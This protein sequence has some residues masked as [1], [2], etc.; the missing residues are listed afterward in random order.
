MPIKTNNELI[1]S[2]KRNSLNESFTTLN[3]KVLN[4]NAPPTITF[5][6]KTPSSNNSSNNSSKSPSNTN[7]STKTSNRS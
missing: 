4:V 2:F 7:K 5:E 6:N 3:N 1:K